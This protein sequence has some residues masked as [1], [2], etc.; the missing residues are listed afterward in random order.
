MNSR[1]WKDL[2]RI[3]QSSA[4]T[5]PALAIIAKQ[6]RR[7]WLTLFTLYFEIAVVIAGI[8]VSTWVMTLDRPNTVLLGG[9]TL[10]L[11]LF[12]GALSFGARLPRR[13][14]PE[15]DVASTLDAAIHRARVSVRWGFATFWVVAA[16]LFF[17]A[18]V[19][20]V[21]AAAPEYSPGVAHRVLVVLGLAT[22]W[23]GAWQLFA[24]VYYL[25][26]ARELA[27][28]EE[29]KRSLAGE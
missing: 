9:G 24:I 8:G 12:A 2:E 5:A 20:L 17:F 23:T 10:L 13:T 4:A 1:E 6:R 26:R 15:N 27:R 25:K 3:W 7:R 11:T 19:A 28:L 29:I 14:A 22:A 18:V 21:W 16:Y